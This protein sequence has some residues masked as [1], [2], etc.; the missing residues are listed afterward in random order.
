MTNRYLYFVHSDD[1]DKFSTS[2][3]LSVDLN[4]FNSADAHGDKDHNRID[5]G[6]EF[7]YWQSYLYNL[8]DSWVNEETGAEVNETSLSY[9]RIPDV[10]NDSIPDGKEIHGYEVK[11]ITGWK[12]D[13]TPI[14]RMRYISPSEL[15]PL[16]P[17]TNRTGVY[18]DSDGDGIPD[19]VEAWFS[20]V[21]MITDSDYR[22]AFKSK[23]GSTLFNEY[24]WVISYF[25]TVYSKDLD[26]HHNRTSA[27]QNATQWLQN[28]FNPLIRDRTP[29]MI[30]KFTLRWE[31]EFSVSLEPVKVYAHVHIV[32]RDAG[33][34]SYLHVVDEDSGEDV[35]IYNAGTVVEVDHK[36]RASALSAVFGSVHIRLTV[37]DYAYNTLTAEKELKGAFEQVLDALKALWDA[38]WNTLCKVVEA[39]AKAVNVILEWVKGLIM[40]II[41]G[42]VDKIASSLKGFYDTIIHLANMFAYDMQN[43]GKLSKDTIL[44]FK[45]FFDSLNWIYFLFLGIVVALDVLTYVINGLTFGVGTLI[46]GIILPL[47][48]TL[49]VKEILEGREYGEVKPSGYLLNPSWAY[50]IDF[51]KSWLSGGSSTQTK[52]TN[53][54]WDMF[55]AGLSIIFGMWN[56]IISLCIPSALP[57][58]WAIASAFVGGISWWVFGI[59]AM[60]ATS[61]GNTVA[62]DI[63]GLM[64][65]IGGTMSLILS[66]IGFY[67][68]YISPKF[69]VGIGSWSAF[70]IA[71]I[72]GGIADWTGWESLSFTP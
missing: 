60:I 3:E 25:W 6:A 54:G 8:W 1:E 55:F 38:I 29:P 19:V 57:Q 37:Q 35:A 72:F 46:T 61:M 70:V 10:D 2:V 13:G 56:W 52:S 67:K 20:N 23:F 28:Q 16:T 44:G 69:T 33:G 66:G 21:S 17:Y 9:C 59:A 5:D 12:S 64:A 41:E 62:G 42:V 68:A 49:V 34:I 39:M 7:E 24:R 26:E 48:L 65:I 58:P 32:V 51:V 27:W 22:Q 30:T 50:V 15:D 31:V 45:S 63:L 43:Y 14:S 40:N 36:F 4:L 11:I 71:C 47:V 53:V 18:L